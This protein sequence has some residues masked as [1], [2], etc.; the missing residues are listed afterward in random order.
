[1]IK[2]SLGT[3]DDA[4][5]RE[6]VERDVRKEERRQS[7][8][9]KISEK[10]NNPAYFLSLYR[11]TGNIRFYDKAMELR[12]SKGQRT[13]IVE[14]ESKEDYRGPEV[15]AVVYEPVNL[16][17]IKGESGVESVMRE[18]MSRGVMTSVGERNL[19]FS[20]HKK[21]KDNPYSS[22]THIESVASDNNL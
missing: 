2:I 3:I 8:S 9:R 19:L 10:N 13:V 1:M 18:E 12:A 11:Q 14:N 20:E 17:E 21:D 22:S 5:V 6:S 4:F 16:E 7:K 15:P